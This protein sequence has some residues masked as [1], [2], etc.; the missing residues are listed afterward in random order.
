MRLAKPISRPAWLVVA[1]ALGGLPVLAAE[2]APDETDITCTNPASGATW[3][4]RIDYGRHTVDANPAHISADEIS[5]QDSKNRWNYKLDRR[6]G[7]LTVIVASSTGG[8]FLHDRC[9]LKSSG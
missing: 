5:W 9:T 7:T 3:Q 6:S 8:Y 1:A 4:I 2:P